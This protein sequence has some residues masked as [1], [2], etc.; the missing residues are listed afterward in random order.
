[1]SLP[2]CG[3]L[4]LAFYFSLFPPQKTP[5]VPVFK[6]AATTAAPLFFYADIIQAFIPALKKLK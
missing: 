6:T 4:V 2:F 1:M 5:Q 3:G